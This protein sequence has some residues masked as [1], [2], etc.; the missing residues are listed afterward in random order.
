MMNNPYAAYVHKL[1]R[2]E[3]PLILAFPGNKAISA[4][5]HDWC[6]GFYTKDTAGR[7]ARERLEI[8]TQIINSVAID[9]KHA[10]LHQ[11]LQKIPPCFCGKCM[12]IHGECFTEIKS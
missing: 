3:K 7:I 12:E 10:T 9:K 5:A 8:I 4:L 11:D 6:A 2:L 1:R